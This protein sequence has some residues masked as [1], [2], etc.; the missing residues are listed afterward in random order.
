MFVGSE[1]VWRK[2]PKGARM[3]IQERAYRQA[4]WSGLAVLGFMAVVTVWTPYQFPSVWTRWFESPRIYFVWAFPLLGLFAGYKLWQSLKTRRE[5]R[6]LIYCILLFLSGY[7]GLLTSLYPYAIPPSVSL[8]E[9]AAQPETLRFTLWGTLIVLPVIIAYMVY[10]YYV[11]RGKV[12]KE[13]FYDS[14]TH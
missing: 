9:A 4:F 7:L 3:T 14:S 1:E 6:P 10:S 12:G 11:F 8:Q 13:K 2:S 5:I